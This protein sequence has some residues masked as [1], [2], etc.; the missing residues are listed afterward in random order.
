MSI[1]DSWIMSNVLIITH[2]LG[3]GTMRNRRSLHGKR[4]HNSKMPRVP[5]KD[6][7]GATIK[8][9]RKKILDRRVNN[10]R[11]KLVDKVVIR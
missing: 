3:V 10:I 4:R 1:P 8:E 2:I 9:C 6:S 11:A 5:F 7:N